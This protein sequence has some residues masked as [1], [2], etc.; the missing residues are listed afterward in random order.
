MKI[1]ELEH[2]GKIHKIQLAVTSYVGGNLAVRM[3]EPVDGELEPWS[4]LTVNLESA[5]PLNCA[6]IDINNNGEGILAWIVRNGLAIPTGKYA[7]SGYCVYPEYYFR[8][9]ILQTLDPEGY[10]EYLHNREEVQQ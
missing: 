4:I 3:N 5:R 2:D 7:H 6:Y 9:E 8:P 10:S 1:F